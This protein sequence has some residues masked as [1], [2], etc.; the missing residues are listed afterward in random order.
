MR[1]AP[2]RHPRGSVTGQGG[3]FGASEQG[4]S[5]PH[6]LLWP[7]FGAPSVLVLGQSSQGVSDGQGQ[8]EGAGDP[9]TSCPF[10]F[11]G[12]EPRQ[13]MGRELLRGASLNRPFLP[14]LQMSE[15]ET[16]ISMVNRMV[17]NSSPRAQIF[18]QVRPLPGSMAPAS[19]H[20][21]CS[22]MV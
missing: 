19:L 7:L 8:A 9:R 2:L 17:E 21:S 15:S 16:L 4:H 1:P 12:S 3:L 13:E 6:P 20:L 11:R 10:L 5:S 22:C 14:S 18:M